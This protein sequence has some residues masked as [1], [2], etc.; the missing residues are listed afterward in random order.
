MPTSDQP[1]EPVSGPNALPLPALR[2]D[3]PAGL[4][5]VG[6][7]AL[8]TDASLSPGSGVSAY[9]HACRRRWLVAT[10]LGILVAA[11]IAPLIWF[12]HKPVYTASAL[13]HVAATQQP[14]LFD[15]DNRVATAFEIYK[16]TQQQYV[17]SRFVILAAL[18]K[19]EVK[20]L[21]VQRESD[22]VEWLTRRLRVEFPGNAE[23][24]TISLQGEN[25][26]AA[27]A[28]VNAVVDAYKT[29][30][31]D[32]EQGQRRQRLNDLDR[33]YTEKETEMRRKRS[34]LK[35]LAEQLGSSER[36]TLNLKQQFTLQQIATYRTEL[37]NTQFK[38]MRNQGELN[39]LEGMEKHP[40]TTEVSEV[41]VNT[42]LWS[43]PT[44]SQLT[45]KIADIK[46]HAEEMKS[47]S[48]PSVA[49][50]RINHL[51]ADEQEIQ[52]L[53]A[54]RR[55]DLREELKRRRQAGL[56]GQIETLKAEKT[57][58]TD[59]EKQLT[60]AVDEAKKQA[61]SFGG[62]SI[63]VE[64]MRGEISFLEGLLKNIADEREK[65]MIE[66]QNRPRITPIGKGAE[67]P[68]A[69]DEDRKLQ[70]TLFGG[71]AGFLVPAGLIVW[72]DVRRRR[73]NVTD[74]VYPSTGLEVIGA[75]PLVPSRAL[76]Q[77]TTISGGSRWR[78]RMIEPLDGIA[79]R[80]LHLAEK[81]RT[82][83]ILVSS[84]VG[85]EGKT[86]LATHL[87]LSLARTGHRTLLVDFDLRHPA[88]DQVMD[89]PLEPGVAEIL[90]KE[91]DYAGA[92]QETSIENLSVLP[93]GRADRQL[94]A[95]LA[96]G[97]VKTLFEQFRADYEFI[98]VDTSPVLPVPDA[99]FLCRHADGVVFSV[100]RD[101][102]NVPN[103]LAACEVLA[104]FG[105]RPIGAVVTGSAGELHY[106]R[107]SLGDAPPG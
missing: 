27:A 47:I 91:I 23:I 65:L 30:V 31:V 57:L 9:L 17:K 97:A 32:V 48:Q 75:V 10:L 71:L 82:Q 106:Q 11:P 107:M 25:P 68:S 24:M 76:Q 36:D 93:A 69:P 5:V 96:N 86:T 72:W 67:P 1:P 79:A 18:R 2:R 38:L 62:S 44:A 100:L 94:L 92:V 64:M 58:L 104:G 43:D 56:H 60:K 49:G 52:R 89:V 14:I 16:S 13:F 85:G 105:V 53:L 80:L 3:V 77:L 70:Y 98:L 83:V 84:A 95:S 42:M 45:Q 35:Q 99:R 41:E 74:E 59:Q 37:M 90:R 46:K 12:L 15:T 33:I 20:D 28:L 7:P 78:E 40:E 63:D 81:D 54:S 87:S 19:P 50:S 61:E 103:I 8:A 21:P 26:Q 6:R 34:E 29:E 66:I 51:Q 73:I 101:V 4:E 39:A 102:S 55:T 88:I 22:P